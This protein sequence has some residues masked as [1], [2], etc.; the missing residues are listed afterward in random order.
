MKR[1]ILALLISFIFANVYSQTVNPLK[2]VEDLKEIQNSVKGKV[3]DEDFSE[4]VTD[5]Y[6]IIILRPR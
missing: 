3:V 6:G 4:Y 1:I 5:K 2:S